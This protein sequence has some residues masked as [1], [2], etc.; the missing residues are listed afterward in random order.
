MSTVCFLN[1]SILPPQSFID[2]DRDGIRQIQAPMEISGHG[3]RVELF[4]IGFM[5]EFRKS[6]AFA[7]EDE[8]GPRLHGAIP[9]CFF[10]FC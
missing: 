3:D 10:R 1:S 5:I 8:R 7:S 9:E 2:R 4:R 6:F